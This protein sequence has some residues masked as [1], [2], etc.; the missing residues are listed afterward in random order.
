MILIIAGNHSQYVYWIRKYKIP[1]N[2]TKYCSQW[3]DLFGYK[4]GTEYM[5][6]GEFWKSQLYN[7][8]SSF[9]RLSRYKRIYNDGG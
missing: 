8:P 2:V 1:L 6:V 7:D 9:Y 5:L 4:D 3:N